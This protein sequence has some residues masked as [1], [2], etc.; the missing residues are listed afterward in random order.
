MASEN[1]ALSGTGKKM[2]GVG[3]GSHPGEPP[4]IDPAKRGHQVTEFFGKRPKSR[5]LIRKWYVG[6][7]LGAR[8]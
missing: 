4:R 3:L 5:M 2:I 6:L 8:E 1:I 7:P